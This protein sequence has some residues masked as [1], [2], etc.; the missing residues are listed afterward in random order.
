MRGAFGGGP[1]PQ[2]LGAALPD[3]FVEKAIEYVPRAVS[4]G[5]PRWETTERPANGKTFEAPVRRQTG[6]VNR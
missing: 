5:K 4:D 3:A 1:L 6:A 2:N